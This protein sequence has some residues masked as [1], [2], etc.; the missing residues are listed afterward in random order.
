MKSRGILALLLISSALSGRPS[1]AQETSGATAL[2]RQWVERL[3]T[4]MQQNATRQDVDNLL[5]LCTDDAVYEHPRMR[6][7]TP[8]KRRI[9]AEMAEYLGETRSPSLRVKSTIEGRNVVVLELEVQAE[10]KRKGGWEPLTRTQVTVLETDGSR[11]R[12][13][14]DYW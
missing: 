12:R 14:L 10:A 11:I 4:V 8:G 13:I 2:A 6:A 9:R 3:T 1:P 5:A 7:R